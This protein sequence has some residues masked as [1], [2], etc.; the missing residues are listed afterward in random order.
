MLMT[1]NVQHLGQQLLFL[2]VL[3]K[4]TRVELRVEYDGNCSLEVISLM[5]SALWGYKAKLGHMN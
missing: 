5:W 2:V 3:Y 1:S 4:K